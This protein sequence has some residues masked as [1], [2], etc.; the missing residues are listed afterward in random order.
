MA[1]KVTGGPRGQISVLSIQESAINGA[2][3][4]FREQ[5]GKEVIWRQELGG[6]GDHSH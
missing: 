4:R 1:C 2:G 6:N 5:C 3:F